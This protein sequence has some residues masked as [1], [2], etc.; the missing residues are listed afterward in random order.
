MDLGC[1]G[2][3]YKNKAFLIKIYSLLKVNNCYDLTIDFEF[4][5]RNIKIGYLLLTFI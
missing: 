4:V 1:F 3:P 5:E 2:G